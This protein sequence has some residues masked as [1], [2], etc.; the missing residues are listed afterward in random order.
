MKRKGTTRPCLPERRS[1]RRE[2]K[3]TAGVRIARQALVDAA[4]ER[5]V[6]AA[7][8]LRPGRERSLRLVTFKVRCAELLLRMAV[9]A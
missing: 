4:R 5:L 1:V 9:G 2:R 3:D 7:L 8:E 6:T